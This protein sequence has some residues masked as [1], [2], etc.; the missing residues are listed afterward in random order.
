M[1]T[2][3]V[4]S[5][6]IAIVISCFASYC[7]AEET[8]A[9]VIPLDEFVRIATKNDTTFEEILINELSLHYT[10]DLEL[11]SRDLV[12]SVKNQYDF[13]LNQDR[14]QMENL[15]GLSKLFPYSGTSVAAAYSTSPSYSNETNSSHLDFYVTQSIARD[16][17]GKG[18]RLLDK[19]VGLEN[20]IARYQIVEA[21]EDYLATVIEAYIDWYESYQ[22]VDIAQSSYN[23][24]VKLLDNIQEREKNKIALPVDVNKIKLQVYDKEESLVDVQEAYQ[25]RLNI[26]KTIMRY[27][28]DELLKP[29]NPDAFFTQPGAFQTD[30][31]KFQTDSRTYKTLNLLEKKSSFEVDKDADDLLPSINLL[32]GYEIEGKRE[33][34]YESDNMFYMGVS[35]EWPI[36]N[37]VERAEWNTSKITLEKTILSNM[38]THY[39]LYRDI[40]NLYLSLQQ[41]ELLFEIAQ[42]KNGLAKAVVK[43]ETENY[44]YGKITLNDFIKAVNTYDNNRLNIA[45]RHAEI[46]RLMLERLRILD[47]LVTR[48][49]I[50]ER[51]DITIEETKD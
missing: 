23:E 20:D 15:V 50:N 48:H 42:K 26:V 33:S 16:A 29:A 1:E 51:H 47:L 38:D 24:N 6:L 7:V 37:Q 13:I 28:G 49:Q 35:M 43:D 9:R 25:R 40:K 3:C 39:R 12:L 41:Q 19:I 21:Y 2:K 27:K 44:M 32:A 31:D 10:K 11:P 5:I 34:F 22:M 17:F 4:I 46:K 18:T 14:S 45:G 8:P 30:Y 36:P